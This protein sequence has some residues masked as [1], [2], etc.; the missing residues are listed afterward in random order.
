MTD[1]AEPWEIARRR[2]QTAALRRREFTEGQ[3]GTAVKLVAAMVDG[4]SIWRGYADRTQASGNGG[5]LWKR[6]TEKEL[7]PQEILDTAPL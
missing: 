7:P 2:R 6:W 1:G 4:G 3:M 5:R